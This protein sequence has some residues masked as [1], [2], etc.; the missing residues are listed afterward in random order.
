MN[1]SIGCWYVASS[2]QLK[3]SNADIQP[4][5]PLELCHLPLLFDAMVA[6]ALVTHAPESRSSHHV[7]PMQDD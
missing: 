2:T 1:E 3:S 7:Y 5:V 4:V 6:I